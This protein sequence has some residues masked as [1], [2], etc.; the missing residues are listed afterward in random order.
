MEAVIILFV[1]MALDEMADPER[2]GRA[3]SGIDKIKKSVGS[4]FP[5]FLRWDNIASS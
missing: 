2:E 3:R 4:D 1:A 5:R